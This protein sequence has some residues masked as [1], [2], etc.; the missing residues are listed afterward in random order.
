MRG[1]QLQALQDVLDGLHVPVHEV[2]PNEN[3]TR[4]DANDKEANEVQR[5]PKLNAHSHRRLRGE[6]VPVGVSQVEE[7]HILR[8][9]G[10]SIQGQSVTWHEVIRRSRLQPH[11]NERHDAGAASYRGLHE[12][13]GGHHHMH[14]SHVPCLVF[15]ARH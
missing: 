3:W 5:V 14:L 12:V 9:M 11:L 4:E 13:M 8:Y 7:R 6:L 1:C 10:L 15:R 2:S